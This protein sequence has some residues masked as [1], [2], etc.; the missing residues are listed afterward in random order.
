MGRGANGRS[1]R[2]G[3]LSDGKRGKGGAAGEKGMEDELLP[4]SRA[5]VGSGG[6][7]GLGTTRGGW[8]NARRNS[9]RGSGVRGK[10]RVEAVS[11]RTV[12]GANGGRGVRETW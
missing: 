2:Q 4:P 5:V 1:A 7:Q 12:A 11:G 8:G 10:A 9:G 6:E 3:G